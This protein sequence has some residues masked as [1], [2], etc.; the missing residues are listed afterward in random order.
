MEALA[1]EDELR[2]HAA[3]RLVDSTIVAISGDTSLSRFLGEIL[4]LM[5]RLRDRES[6]LF[7]YSSLP[8][9]RID[10]SFRDPARRRSTGERGGVSGSNQLVAALQKKVLLRRA[11]ALGSWNDGP[12]EAGLGH[13][14]PSNSAQE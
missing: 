9:N 14:G 3:T 1:M 12:N 10:Q 5:D 6:I 13:K 11:H 7:A 2:L 4:V 8:M